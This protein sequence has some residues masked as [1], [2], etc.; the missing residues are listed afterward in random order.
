MTLSFY[1]SP[2]NCQQVI[3]VLRWHL[4]RPGSC[5]L[6]HQKLRSVSHQKRRCPYSF[7]DSLI[8]ISDPS[9]R[10]GCFGRC[11]T[12]VWDP[13]RWRRSSHCG[14]QLGKE[15]LSQR[16]KGQENSFWFSKVAIS[17][18]VTISP[19]SPLYNFNI[20]NNTNPTGW[21]WDT[22]L[23]TLNYEILHAL[24]YVLNVCSKCKLNK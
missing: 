17:F 13:G 4:I 21:I 7:F 11:P 8:S 23:P 18:W 3:M 22:P 19:F 20:R 16:P 6:F 12:Q 9:T 14:W 2:Y 5:M 24:F 15:E 1:P 10:V